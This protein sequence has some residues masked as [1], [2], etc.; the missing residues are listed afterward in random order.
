MDMDVHRIYKVG[1][2]AQILQVCTKT[3]YQI[4]HDGDL[5]VIR[6]RGQLRITAEALEKYIEGGTSHEQIPNRDAL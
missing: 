6:V 2:I 1:E 4:I 3:V 5:E